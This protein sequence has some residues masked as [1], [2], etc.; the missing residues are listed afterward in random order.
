[1]PYHVCFDASGQRVADLI[2]NG[3]SGA[4]PSLSHGAMLLFESSLLFMAGPWHPGHAEETDTP[5]PASQWSEPRCEKPPSLGFHSL[6]NTY[7]SQ[8]CQ[9]QSLRLLPGQ[10]LKA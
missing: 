8:G 4:P 1:M 6:K 5:D 10:G 9:E 7:I 2:C 3:S